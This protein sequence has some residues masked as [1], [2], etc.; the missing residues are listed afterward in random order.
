MDDFLTTNMSY[1]ILSGDISQTF[2]LGVV[3]VPPPRDVFQIVAFDGSF[4]TER[5]LS[6]SRCTKAFTLS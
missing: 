1:F 4:P 3:L 5:V 2:N 6:G